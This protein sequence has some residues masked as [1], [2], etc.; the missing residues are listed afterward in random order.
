MGSSLRWVPLFCIAI[1]LLFTYRLYSSAYF[2]L[3]DFDNLYWVQPESASQM[4]WHIVNPASNFF[5]PAGMLFY[6]LM[7]K[8]FDLNAPTYHA[9]AWSLHAAN[10]VLVYFILKRIT[11]SRAGAAVGCLLF[12][13]EA[14]FVDL[15]WS[16]GSIFELVCGLAMFTGILLW[17]VEDRSWARSILSFFV[18]VFAFKAKEMAVTLP[19]I[20]LGCDQLLRR[21]PTLKSAL[22]LVPCV[23][24]GIWYGWFKVT[25][26][27]APSQDAPYFMDVRL[28]TFVRGYGSYF[29]QLFNS[30]FSFKFWA[31]GFVALLLAFVLMNQRAAI[32]FQGYLFITFLPVIFL[33]NHRYPLFWYIP[34]LGVCGL[35]AL[36][37]KALV[38]IVESKFPG[39][40]PA[41]AAAAIFAAL[42]WGSYI[43]QRDAT[44]PRRL[45]QQKI[46]TEYRS[47]V[48]SVRAM[49]HPAPNET[50]VFKSYPSYFDSEVLRNATQVALRR[51][52]IDAKLAS[53][54]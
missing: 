4:F 41:V 21:R 42:S 31:I 33:I 37:V 20:W 22:Q 35:A 27:R 50:I 25:E 54:Q 49:P 6:W 23:L 10:T 2:W 17:N 43:V 26:M 34:I 38:G 14:V 36:L 47:W 46:D 13:S 52:D 29:N 24:F 8:L 18:F 16:F 32:F 40:I 48:A 28:R 11:D 5:R 30:N 3:D 39:S 19:V 7:L 53:S 9:L 51:T 45:W 12:A 1:L 44:A 15:Y